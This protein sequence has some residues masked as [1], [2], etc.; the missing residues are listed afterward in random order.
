MLHKVGP[1]RTILLMKLRGEGLLMNLNHLSQ[2]KLRKLLTYVREEKARV[3]VA[4]VG[5]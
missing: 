5:S 4:Q 2:S 1:K 3:A